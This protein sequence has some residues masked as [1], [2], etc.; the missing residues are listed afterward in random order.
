MAANRKRRSPKGNS[1]VDTRIVDLAKRAS[2]PLLNITPRQFLRAV[3]NGGALIA[4]V[5]GMIE[6]L[7]W[8]GGGGD[9]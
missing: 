7:A 4:S 6:L 1:L 2:M 5:R 8:L 3:V 9:A